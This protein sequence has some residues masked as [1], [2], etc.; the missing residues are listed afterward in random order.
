MRS[1]DRVK[2]EW[3]KNA[4]DDWYGNFT[5]SPELENLIFE[6]LMLEAASGNAGA[7]EDLPEGAQE[8][9]RWIAALRAIDQ[10]G[11]IRLLLDRLRAVVPPFVFPHVADLLERK[12]VPRG[13]GKP[14]GPSYSRSISG[15]E[16][17]LQVAIAHVK[18]LTKQGMPLA[19]ALTKVAEMRGIPL[20]MLTDAQAGHRGASRRKK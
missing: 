6:R 13:R 10:R 4:D 3:W 19:E 1:P 9:T 5:H 7:W 17:T 14:R 16:F 20:D 11:D 2:T 15:P 12:L 18:Y 8:A